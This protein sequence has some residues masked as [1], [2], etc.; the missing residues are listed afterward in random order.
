[1]CVDLDRL[2]AT[3][4][5]LVL[6]GGANRVPGVVRIASDAGLRLPLGG[7]LNSL[8]IRMAARWLAMLDEPV[9]YSKRTHERW[10]RW[11]RKSS[12]PERWDRVRLSDHAVRDFIRTEL[13]VHPAATRSGLLR[14]L[15]AAG[16]AC[17][18]SRFG[19][20]F[21]DEQGTRR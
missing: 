16:L 5:P 21:T 7:T 18:Q 8:N 15:R 3:G 1:M 14:N 6:F 19:A 10:R 17:E 2:G 13:D 11:A 9:L 4:K 12:R 20:L